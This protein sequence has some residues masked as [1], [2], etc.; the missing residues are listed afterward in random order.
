MDRRTALGLGAASLAALAASAAADEPVWSPSRPDPA[1]VIPLWPGDAPGMPAAKPVLAISE[2][3]TAPTEYHDRA[4]TG[5]AVPT[6]TVF[7]PAKPDGSALLIAPGGGYKRV[8]IDKEGFE[9]ARRLNEAGVT[10]F[11]LL[12]RLPGEGWSDAADVP[13]QDAQ[14]AIRIIRANASR[15][16]IDP[17]RTG[18]LGFSAGGHVAASLATRSAASVYAP[19]D[20]QDE[21]DAKPALRGADVPGDHHVCRARAYGLAPLSARRQSERGAGGGPVL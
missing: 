2:R 13:L 14:R 4:A 5:I 8:V 3:S 9:A 7:R 11:V 1:E 16:A 19:V 20:P 12:Y 21:A 17:A 15:F 18:V 6:L 10:S